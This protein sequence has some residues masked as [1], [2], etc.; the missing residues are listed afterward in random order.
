M[1]ILPPTGLVPEEVNVE[2]QETVASRKLH[3]PP[4]KP[5]GIMPE[6]G[7]GPPAATRMLTR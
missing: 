1:A 5:G 6:P 4:G 3:S 2:E 7:E